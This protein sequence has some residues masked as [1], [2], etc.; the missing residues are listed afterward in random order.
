MHC[1]D[2]I[3]CSLRYYDPNVALASS[4]T[5]CDAGKGPPDRTPHSYQAREIKRHPRNP[6]A[7]VP[8][9]NPAGVTCPHGMESKAPF[10]PEVSRGN[11]N[12]R[13]DAVAAAGVLF[14]DE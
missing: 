1:R 13:T 10:K 7:P 11:C 2:M 4:M 8:A 14:P 5:T 9:A 12:L 3:A 6:P